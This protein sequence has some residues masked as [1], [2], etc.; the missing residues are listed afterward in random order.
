MLFCVSVIFY[1]FAADS[2]NIR[3]RNNLCRQIGANNITCVLQSGLRFKIKVFGKISLVLVPN[4]LV[5]VVQ[6]G[7][8]ITFFEIKHRIFTIF[9][10]KSHTHY[11]RKKNSARLS[12]SFWRVMYVSLVFAAYIIANFVAIL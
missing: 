4:F 1:I 8:Q 9:Q 5:Y 2:S 12:Q 6:R 10:H 11:A 3:L 7:D